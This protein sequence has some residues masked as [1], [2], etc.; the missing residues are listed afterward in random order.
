[1]T[2]TPWALT[3]AGRTLAP[4]SRHLTNGRGEDV[5]IL[6]DTRIPEQGSHHVFDSRGEPLAFTA[7]QN[8]FHEL[9]HARHQTDGTWHEVAVDDAGVNYV[10]SVV[11]GDSRV[12]LGGVEW[13]D[14]YYPEEG[15]GG[16]SS[17]LV[18]LIGSP[19][20]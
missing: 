14:S 17:N 16:G 11:V 20:E 12:L 1:M 3:A 5:M 18:V 19:A 2:G 4:V 6:F 7:V 10:S 9:A 13:D 8:L 15:F